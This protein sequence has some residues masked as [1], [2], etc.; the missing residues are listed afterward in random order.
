M[1]Q[2]IQ[3]LEHLK[4]KDMISVAARATHSITIPNCKETQ[5]HIID[6]F[7]KN[8]ADLQNKLTVMI[9]HLHFY[10]YLNLT[11]NSPEQ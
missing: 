3:A 6:L 10:F 4:F 5:K 2:P 11:A 1:N 9:Y 8:I 7:K